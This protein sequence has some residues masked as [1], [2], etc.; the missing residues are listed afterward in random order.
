MPPPAETTGDT[1]VLPEQLG[2]TT[3]REKFDQGWA[4]TQLAPILR[5]RSAESSWNRIRT[6]RS[7]GFIPDSSGR[8]PSRV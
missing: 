5:K 3:A 4:P 1:D 7:I 8:E 2:R 6:R